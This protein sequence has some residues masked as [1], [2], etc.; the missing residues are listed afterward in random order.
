MLTHFIMQDEKYLRF[1]T[2]AIDLIRKDFKLLGGCQVLGGEDKF[3]TIR[4]IQMKV[5]VYHW[6][7]SCWWFSLK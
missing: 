2:V 4:I 1:V 3:S 5:S 7:Q 6:P